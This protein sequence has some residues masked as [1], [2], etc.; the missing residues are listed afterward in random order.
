LF[1]LIKDVIIHFDG[2]NDGP[3]IFRATFGTEDL[4]LV[5]GISLARG[6]ELPTLVVRPSGAHQV[7]TRTLEPSGG[8]LLGILHI[9][10]T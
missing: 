10:L 3:P 9:N 1:L 8:S 6:Y 7:Q 4:P 5:L 2:V